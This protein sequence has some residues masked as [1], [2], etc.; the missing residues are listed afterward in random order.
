MKTSPANGPRPRPS[1]T[2]NA[3]PLDVSPHGG[4]TNGNPDPHTQTRP[5]SSPLR[6]GEHPGQRGRII[7]SNDNDGTILP[8][9]VSLRPVA[10]E[11]GP[12]PPP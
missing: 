1:G 3:R 10:G 8:G 9:S 12:M 5:G 6:N 4:A 11:L 7:A 2:S